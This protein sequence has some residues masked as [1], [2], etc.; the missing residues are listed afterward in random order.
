VDLFK[1]I[2]TFPKTLVA[3]DDPNDALLL[4]CAFKRAGVD[5][6]IHFVSDGVE[7][8]DYLRGK[9]LFEKVASSTLPGLLLLD[10]EMPRL[11]GFGV[12]EWLRKHPHLRPYRVVVISASQNAKDMER[13]ASMGADLCLAK[14]CDPGELG[15]AVKLLEDC[16]HG[17]HLQQLELSA[18]FHSNDISYLRSMARAG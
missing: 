11:S 18:T 8:I 17:R 14:T 9:Q 15:Q 10:L 12:L 5:A 6:T 2:M 4:H 13:A 16:F 1:S 7:A 3:E